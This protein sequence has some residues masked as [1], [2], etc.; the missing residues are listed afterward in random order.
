M[1][2]AALKSF[3]R[4]YL[5]SQPGPEVM[6][7][8]QGGEPLL[9]GLGFYRRALELQWKYARPGTRITNT[10]QTN[11]TLLD[12]EWCRFFKE[13]DFLVGISLD[14]PAEFHDVYRL[15]KGEQPTFTAVMAGL[16]LLQRHDVAFNVLTCVHAANVDHP[17]RLYRFLRDEVGAQFLQ[18]IPIV[19][20]IDAGWGQEDVRV[21]DRSLTARQ[22]GRFLI[23][24]FDEWLRHDVGKVFVQIF[25]VALGQWLGAP[26]SLCIFAPT[27]GN[28]LVLEHNG[29]LYSCDHFVEPDHFLGNIRE[30]PLRELVF[31][32]KQQQFGMAKATNLP[33]YC[34]TC[35]V[36]F[37]CQGGCPRNRFIKTPTGEEGLNYLCAGYKAFFRHID[38]P[39][40]LMRAKIA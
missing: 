7:T 11:G 40:R 35:E 18:F 16:R 12:D 37:A 29:D 34:R 15:D 25:D 28:A 1:S 26:P 36:F 10:V 5:A 13:T 19:E 23:D 20:R 27:C 39:M 32:S 3:I 24:I 14:G 31:S 22:Y 9:M 8:W 4:Q 38:R 33:S 2:E 6:F 21:T 30:T 17:R